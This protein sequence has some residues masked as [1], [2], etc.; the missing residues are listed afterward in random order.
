[1]VGFGI[2]NV[3][4]MPAALREMRRVLRPGGRLVVL[5]FSMPR[6]VLGPIYR[7][8]FDTILPRIGAAISGDRSAYAYLPASVA[9]FPDPEG[10]AAL[11]ADAGFENVGFFPLTGGIAYLHCGA[12]P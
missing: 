4:D 10:L 1:V 2:R 8:Y 9:R 7:L 11:L 3:G 6:G 12:R 5:E